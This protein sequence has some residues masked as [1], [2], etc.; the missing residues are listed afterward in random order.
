LLPIHP[1]RARGWYAWESREDLGAAGRRLVLVPC[2]SVEQHGPHLPVGTDAWIAEAVAEQV[3]R[4]RPG[5][6]LAEPLAYGCSSHHRGFAGT[7]SLHPQ[8]FIALI[9]DVAASLADNGYVPVFVN[10]HGGNRGALTVA[11][12]TLLD[13]GVETWVISYFELLEG[14]LAEALPDYHDAV[15][16]A[17]ALETSL[18]LHLWPDAV[19]LDQVPGPGARSAWPDPFLYSKDRIIRPRLIRELDPNGVVGRPASASAELGRLMFEAA[20]RRVGDAVDRIVVETGA[21]CG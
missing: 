10:G 17:C 20:V 7:V 19:H 13:Q 2:G 5:V 8:T 16:H 14:D 9:I 12:Q 3:A 15:G 18:V 4:A 6:Y 21:D 1:V 11:A